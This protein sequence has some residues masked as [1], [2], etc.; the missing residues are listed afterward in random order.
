MLRGCLRVDGIYVRDVLDIETVLSETLPRLEEI[1]HLLYSTT[2]NIPQTGVDILGKITGK[3]IEPAEVHT[4]QVGKDVEATPND[5]TGS[6]KPVEGQTFLHATEIVIP[7]IQITF[8][9]PLTKEI[10]QQC[11]ANMS[12][13]QNA[14]KELQIPVIQPGEGLSK[15]KQLELIMRR[16]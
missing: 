10:N 1:S 6:R 15:A 14:R 8:S 9:D 7:A 4:S 12:S 16:L 3:S 13:S 11:R 5:K 2:M